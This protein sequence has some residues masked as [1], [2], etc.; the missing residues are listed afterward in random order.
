MGLDMWLLA[1][2][3]GHHRTEEVGYWRKANAVH[4][5][6]DRR[7]G[8]IG[9]CVRVEVSRKN[10]VALYSDCLSVLD[11][12]LTPDACL[13]TTHGFFFGSDEYGVEYSQHLR[14]TVEIC[15]AALSLPDDCD[16][17]YEAWW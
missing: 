11:A 3:C 7:L 12:E 16:F 14:E 2:E 10:L 6:L 5:W 9:N 8:G 15:V 13:P 17:F 1:R 4:G